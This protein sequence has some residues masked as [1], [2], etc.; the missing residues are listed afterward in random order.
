MNIKAN[1]YISYLLRLWQEHGKEEDDQWI[2]RMS[3]ESPQTGERMGFANLAEL[4]AF[5]KEQT[6]HGSG[7]KT[8]EENNHTIPQA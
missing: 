2:W 7:H 5:L 8:G 6:M 1:R 3:L 4:C